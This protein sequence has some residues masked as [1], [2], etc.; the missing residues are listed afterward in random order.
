[1]FFEWSFMHH[2]DR[3]RLQLH[4]LNWFLKASANGMFVPFPPVPAQDPLCMPRGLGTNILPG[5]FD[6]WKPT[7]ME[8]KTVNSGKEWAGHVN[9]QM[10]TQRLSVTSKQPV[11]LCCSLCAS[12]W[13]EISKP[14][15]PCVGYCHHL[16]TAWRMTL[17]TDLLTGPHIY[18]TVLDEGPQHHPGSYC[19]NVY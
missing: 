4:L 17:P 18:C 8:E 10:T 16:E 19:T 12:H 6:S 7:C 14:V 15:L 5:F 1:M 9:A 13:W 11:Y 3:I 2:T